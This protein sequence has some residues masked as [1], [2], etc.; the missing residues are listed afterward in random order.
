MIASNQMRVCSRLCGW[1]LS[2][3]TLTLI[4][5]KNATCKLHGCKCML[6]E[7]AELNFQRAGLQCLG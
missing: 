5:P 4:F 7:A 1:P 3:A 2:P 6:G